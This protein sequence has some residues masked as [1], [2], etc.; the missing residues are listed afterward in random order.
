MTGLAD[1]IV[2]GV[3]NLVAS[4]IGRA[5]RNPYRRRERAEGLRERALVEQRRA[6]TPAAVTH[7]ELRVAELD[8]RLRSLDAEIAARPLAV[9]PA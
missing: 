9:A 3:F 5:E 7:W 6:R 1:G 4:L 8:G 2:G